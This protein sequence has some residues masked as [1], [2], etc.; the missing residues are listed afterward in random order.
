M[1]LEAIPQALWFFLPA[2]VANPMAVV[3][4]GGTPIDFGRTL[5]DH[6]RLFG[7]G[8]TWRGLVGGTLS[9]AFLGLLLTVPFNLFAPTS[10]WSF[11]SVGAAFGASAVLAFGALL[12]SLTIPG[13]SVPRFFSGDA[14]LGLVAIILITPALHRAVNVIGF[15]I[16]QK[17]EPW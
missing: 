9:G 11:G 15:R 12:L 3:F 1:A 13:W 7:D 8:K 17:Q 14:L 4:G 16:G 10:T 2:F 6:E 5:G